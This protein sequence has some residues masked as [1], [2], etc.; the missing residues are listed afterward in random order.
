MPVYSRVSPSRGTLRNQ[1]TTPLFSRLCH[2]GRSETLAF[3][4]QNSL[5]SNSVL[6]FFNCHI[7]PVYCERCDPREPLSPNRTANKRCFNTTSLVV[8]TVGAI[9]MH[10]IP[11]D[12]VYVVYQKSYLFALKP[13]GGARACPV[14][15][16]GTVFP[17]VL[18]VSSSIFSC[19]ACSRACA[20]V[21]VCVYV[22]VCV[23][24][25]GVRVCDAVDLSRSCAIR[26]LFLTKAKRVICWRPA[27]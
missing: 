14:S 10:P 3:V 16:A 26:N 8:A 11:C 7:L 22:C 17:K 5:L 18:P 24:C 13:C 1:Q 21:F 6:T 19:S 23:L 12:I 20:C 9:T 4:P 27:G 25:S 2:T 15:G